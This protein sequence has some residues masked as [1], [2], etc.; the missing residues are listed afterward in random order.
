MQCG[1]IWDPGSCYW[2]NKVKEVGVRQAIRL[3]AVADERL[4]VRRESAPETGKKP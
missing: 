4:F 3:N 2:T 1:S